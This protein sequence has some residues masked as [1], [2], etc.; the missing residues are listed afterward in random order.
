MHFKKYINFNLPVLNFPFVHSLFT[1]VVAV[2]WNGQQGEH[3]PC[4]YRKHL[5]VA[6]WKVSKASSFLNKRRLRVLLFISY[7]THSH[8]V[9]SE[10]KRISSIV[11]C[12]NSGNII[13]PA[14]RSLCY[15]SGRSHLATGRLFSGRG[16]ECRC[17][18]RSPP[19]GQ[20]LQLD[21]TQKVQSILG[22]NKQKSS[23]LSTYFKQKLA[24]KEGNNTT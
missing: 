1:A 19:S 2:P 13:V 20:R 7:R 11:S 5:Q 9:R 4:E 8:L 14:V 12:I 3:T 17:A 21:A 6:G 23:F 16:K 15:D 18:R 10:N 24:T 22:L